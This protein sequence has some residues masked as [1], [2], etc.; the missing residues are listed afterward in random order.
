M[1]KS[2]LNKN[3]M[4]VNERNK[5]L[6]LNYKPFIIMFLVFTH[7]TY[8]RLYHWIRFTHLQV[9]SLEAN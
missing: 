7:G 3:M 4:R 5:E 9:D 8:D 2:T 1:I 6:L